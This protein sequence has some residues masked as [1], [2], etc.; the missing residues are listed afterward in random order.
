MNNV[1]EFVVKFKEQ[2]MDADEFEMDAQTEFRK[3]GTW[4]SLTGMSILVMIKDEFNIDF[5]EDKF[6]ACK[7]AQEV[8][9]AVLK[10]K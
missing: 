1:N 6:R 4:D 9:D 2:Y 10:M 7:T 5:P 8:Y 3:V